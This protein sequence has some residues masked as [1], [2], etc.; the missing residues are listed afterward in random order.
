MNGKTQCGFFNDE[1]NKIAQKSNS[2]IDDR[3]DKNIWPCLTTYLKVDVLQDQA[4]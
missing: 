1:I 2:E 3:G 4:E